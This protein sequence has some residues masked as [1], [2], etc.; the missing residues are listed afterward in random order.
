MTNLLGVSILIANGIGRNNLFKP[1]VAN[2]LL[3]VTE[4]LYRLS[5]SPRSL[6]INPFQKIKYFLKKMHPE[7]DEKLLL[8]F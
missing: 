7:K 5:L 1:F 3:E 6:Y 8:H 2:Y 4:G